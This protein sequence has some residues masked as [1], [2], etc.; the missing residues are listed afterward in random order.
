V[1]VVA[2]ALTF[3]DTL[4]VIRRI[5]TF[6]RR[7]KHYKLTGFFRALLGPEDSDKES[8]SES[9]PEYIGLIGEEVDSEEVKGHRH[10]Y[11]DPD[12]HHPQDFDHGNTEQW[13][14]HVRSHSTMSDGT[15]FGPAS[16]H[17][18]VT[19]HDIH[20]SPR[21]S[22]LRR[23]GRAAF[24]VTEWALVVAGFGLFLTGIVIYTGTY[25]SMRE[26]M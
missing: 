13:A 5:V 3:I 1:L 24:A 11:D 25:K 21:I 19:L 12:T 26:C 4:G 22:L 10:S 6:V 14:N 8:L 23:I 7:E 20:F 15:L 17:S 9:D 2:L 16:P 18:D